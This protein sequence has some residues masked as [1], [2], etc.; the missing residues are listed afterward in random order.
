[1]NGAICAEASV[2][3]YESFV[4]TVHSDMIFNECL[5]GTKVRQD[6]IA[7][8]TIFQK[9]SIIDKALLHHCKILLQM[10]NE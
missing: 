9:T 4:I 7:H 5:T 1:M 8:E 3:F 2:M 10:E 6:E